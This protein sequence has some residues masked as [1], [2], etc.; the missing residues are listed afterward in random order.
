MSSILTENNN[1][2]SSYRKELPVSSLFKWK[3]SQLSVSKS[4][5]QVPESNFCITTYI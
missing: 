3:M 5:I 2:L 1:H 4:K